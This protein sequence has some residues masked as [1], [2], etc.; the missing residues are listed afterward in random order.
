M[1]TNL[2]LALALFSAGVVKGQIQVAPEGQV[3]LGSSQLGQEKL[4]TN[5]NVKAESYGRTF[6]A[7]SSTIAFC[8]NIKVRIKFFLA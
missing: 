5:L 7:F 3:T 1:R 8:F 2:L 6:G 4:Y